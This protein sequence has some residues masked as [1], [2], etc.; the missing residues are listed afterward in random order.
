MKRNGL[1]LVFAALLLQA[2]ATR[3][4]QLDKDSCAK[5]KTEQAQLEQVG[6]RGSIGKG[7]DWGKANLAP[8]KLEQIRRLIEVDEQLLF[9]CGGRPLVLMPS[10]PDPAALEVEGKDAAKDPPAKATKAPAPPK[11]APDAEK[12]AVPLKKAA[13]PPADQ[14]AKKAPRAA[15]PATTVPQLGSAPALAVPAKEAAKERQPV[16]TTPQSAAVPFAPPPPT[17]AKEAEDKKA[18]AIK[19]AK[20]K[21]K[22]KADDAY[23]PLVP[24]WVSSPFA[25][26]APAPAKK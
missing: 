17:S 25:N 10:D 9:R 15:P 3:A 23:S 13:A 2:P 8:E 16:N 18:A 14:P 5:L 11:K 24:D 20:A 4:A 26:Q 22:K 6:T 1:S 7:P 21:A 19:A 12:K